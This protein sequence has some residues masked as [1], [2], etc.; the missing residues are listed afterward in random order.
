MYVT[1]IR[2]STESEFSKTPCS[3]WLFVFGY[4]KHFALELIEN[5][6][7]AYLLPV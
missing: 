7:L 2:H 4:H 1:N 3:V 6:E 5:I